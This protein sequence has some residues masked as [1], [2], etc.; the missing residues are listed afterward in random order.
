MKTNEEKRIEKTIKAIKKLYGCQHSKVTHIYKDV[1]DNE[2]ICLVSTRRYNQFSHKR[3]TQNESI[4][5]NEKCVWG[6]RCGYF[7]GLRE[8]RK[9]LTHNNYQLVYKA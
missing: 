9:H 2:F 7:C 1:R 5:M 8:M 6:C 3:L 4:S